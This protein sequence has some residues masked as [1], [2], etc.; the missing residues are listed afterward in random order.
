MI[1]LRPPM[2]VIAAV[3][4]GKDMSDLFPDVI[5]CIQTGLSVPLRRLSMRSLGLQMILR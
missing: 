3:T 5:G 1:P 4:V 2:Q